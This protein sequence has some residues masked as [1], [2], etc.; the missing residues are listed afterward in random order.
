MTDR[1]AVRLELDRLTPGPLGALH[2]LA[3]DSAAEAIASGLDPR[4]LEL[5]RLR[6]S[7]LNGCRFCLDVHTRQAHIAGEGEARLQA[8]AAWRESLL[9]DEGERAALALTESVTLLHDGHV[10]RE[11]YEPARAH[12]DDTQLAHLLWTI[13][14]INTYNRLALAARVG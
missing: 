11:V 7:Q 10:P 4:L 2:G 14:I 5:V 6:A 8:L 12:F 9:F 3:S 13:A 1:H